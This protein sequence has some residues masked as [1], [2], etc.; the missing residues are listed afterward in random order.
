MHAQA[1]PEVAAT[2]KRKGFYLGESGVL[3]EEVMIWAGMDS[4]AG[5]IANGENL[6]IMNDGGM[7]FPEIAKVIRKN[8]K[9]L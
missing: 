7:T 2:Q 1:H 4:D 8:W 3:P 6:A 9:A 5:V